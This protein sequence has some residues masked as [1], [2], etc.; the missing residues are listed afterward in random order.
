M[1]TLNVTTIIPDAGGTNTDLSLD[2]KGT[3]KVAVVDDASVGGDVLVTGNVG[4]GG[5][6]DFSQ[7]GGLSIT[8]NSVPMRVVSS[9]ATG[10]IQLGASGTSAYPQLAVTG[11][12]LT[13]RTS[14]SDRMVIESGG[15]IDV[16]AG[17]IFFSTGAKGIYLGVTSA[18]ASNLL[19]D[20]EEG[21]WTATIAGSTSNP[22]ST[23]TTTCRY[24]K[25]GRI[26]HAAG[27]F[28]SVDTTGA[29][30]GVRI[31][32]LPF[33]VTSTEMTGNVGLFSIFTL[34]STCRN[35]SPYVEG[36]TISFYQSVSEGGWSEI[37]HNA[38]SGGYLYFSVTY[39]TT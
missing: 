9:A 30:G 17:N 28:A 21:T 37:L 22:S 32:G 35:I 2:G 18:T 38:G 1:S 6:S 24:T 5:A 13:L 8:G 23:V 15:N 11:D 25:I 20:Y 36:T 14:Y 16:E 3:G 12:N 26:V 31:T 33:T 34:L 29:A 27:N 4:V 7:V 19:D 39:T 10:Y